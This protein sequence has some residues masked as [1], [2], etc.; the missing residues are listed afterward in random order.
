MKVYLS[1]S[2]ACDFRTYKKVRELL[3]TLD[4]EILEF[5]GGTYSNKD[6]LR[7]DMMVVIPPDYLSRTRHGDAQKVKI[8]RGQY[9]QIHDFLV[10]NYEK[11][12]EQSSSFD[13]WE[14]TS[15]KLVLLVSHIDEEGGGVYVEEIKGE[16]IVDRENWKLHWGETLDFNMQ[17]NIN[18]YI[19][20][21]KYSNRVD[22]YKDKSTGVIT[23]PSQAG[24][25][26]VNLKPVLHLACKNLFK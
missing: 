10:K 8:G 4:C 16:R 9:D 2:N 26:D 18:N 6:V 3:E 23:L 19:S 24:K 22:V 11:V 20:Q 17:I 21:R 25:K 7:S 13:L 14:P 12:Y 1:K 15:D 5:S